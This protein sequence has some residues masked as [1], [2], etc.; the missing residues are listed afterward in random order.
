M[1]AGASSL[2]STHTEGYPTHG[3]AGPLTEANECIDLWGRRREHV[4]KANGDSSP[5]FL[6][7]AFLQRF[8]L[9]DQGSILTH[10]M[11]H[12]ALLRLTSPAHPPT[13]N[14]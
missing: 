9:R 3:E 4:S 6:E 10:F 12:R 7:A 13:E 14:T 2:A 1:T 5:T 8:N 11:G